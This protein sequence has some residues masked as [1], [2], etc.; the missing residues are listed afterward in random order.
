MPDALL[1]LCLVNHN[2]VTAPEWRDIP[3]KPICQDGRRPPFVCELLT[4]CE[5]SCMQQACMPLIVSP[6]HITLLRNIFCGQDPSAS[7]CLRVYK[8]VC[9]IA[10]GCGPRKFGSQGPLEGPT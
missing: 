7:L 8:I 5:L 9:F 2:R 10:F 4:L 3:A 1:F 6:C